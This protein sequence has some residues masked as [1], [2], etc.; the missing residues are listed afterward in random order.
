MVKVT[1]AGTLMW[2]AHFC[3]K[4]QQEPGKKLTLQRVVNEYANTPF[5]GWIQW[6]VL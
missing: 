6:K 1:K 3:S 4:Q 5:G 2:L